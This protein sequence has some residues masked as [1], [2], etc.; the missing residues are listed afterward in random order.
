MGLP[1]FRVIRGCCVRSFAKKRYTAPASHGVEHIE[2]RRDIQYMGVALKCPSVHYDTPYRCL[3]CF[4][5]LFIVVMLLCWDPDP[6][7]A[8]FVAFLLLVVVRKM[9]TS[10][11]GQRRRKR[12]K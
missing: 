1:R 8:A 10:R 12:D 2:T 6:V 5:V 7:V 11:P 3:W 9:K 4:P